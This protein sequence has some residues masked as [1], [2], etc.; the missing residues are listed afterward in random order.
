VLTALARREINRG[1]TVYKRRAQ[2]AAPRILARVTR[3]LEQSARTI[4]RQVLEVAGCRAM[5]DGMDRAY[6]RARK[7]MALAREDP[8]GAGLHRWRRRV[9]DHWYQMRLLEGVNPHV[10]GRVRGLRRLETWLGDHHDLAV[11]H[12]LV[13][14]APARFGGERA[15]AEL[16][17]CIDK[18]KEMLGRR[19]WKNGARLFAPARFSPRSIGGGRD[20]ALC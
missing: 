13:L 10:R 8:D 6:R 16:L 17:G 18:R 7:A 9:K 20:S 12:H 4:P 3:M 15:V 11:L 1:L 14:S 5:R 19:A 2:L